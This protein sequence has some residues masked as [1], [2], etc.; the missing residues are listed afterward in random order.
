M[1]KKISVFFISFV[2]CCFNFVFAQTNIDLISTRDLISSSSSSSTDVS[3]GNSVSGLSSSCLEAMS[4]PDYMVTAGDV[5]S[6]TY[7]ANTTP[8]SYTIVV[9]S[10]YRIRVSNLAILDAKGK[11][12]LA[13]KK[14]VEEIVQKNY[15]LSG[16]QFVLINPAVFKVIVKGEISQTTE[17]SVWALTRLSSIIDKV[18]TSFSSIRNVTITSSDK[19][20]K[21]YDLFKARREGDL[22]Q[23]PYVRPGDVITVKRANRL[24]YL[25]GSVDRP[26][27]YE[28]LPGEN[29]KELIDYYGNGF[30]YY[31]DR[32]KIELLRQNIN[33]DDD[34]S[35]KIYL[36]EDAYNDNFEL[37]SFDR[38]TISNSIDLLPMIFVEGAVN[39]V[40]EQKSNL[41]V[42]YSVS[43]SSASSSSLTSYNKLEM[44]FNDGED[45]ST[46]VRRNKGIFTSVSDLENAYIVRGAE[47]IPLNLS[48][49]IYDSSYESHVSMEKDDILLVPFKQFFVTVSGA[50][51]APGRYPYIP[52]RTW[53]YYIGLAG[54]FIKEKNANSAVRITDTDGNVHKKD[55]YILPEMTIEAKCNSGLYYFNQYAPVITTVLSL[56][57]SSISIITVVKAMN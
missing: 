39:S 4:N 17:C 12:Y 32:S 20:S 27:T 2:V 30:S 1:N 34:T 23:N 57:T 5:Y 22:S 33:N 44:R 36:K 29:L 13:L 50:V 24:V 6:L 45:Y 35:K 52:D 31:A 38:I 42:S 26:G 16:V 28:L 51:Y 46:F 37:I 49:M 14:E 11:S 18:T 54:G 10:T 9:D 3:S 8:I 55:D 43:S 7:A 19:K 15:P 56:I 47:H 21:S 41:S 48:K 25:E 53:D 40:N